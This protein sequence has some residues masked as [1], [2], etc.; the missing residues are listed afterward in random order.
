MKLTRRHAQL[1]AV[2]A[3][4]LGAAVAFALPA[5]AAVISKSPPA[6]VLKLGTT[7]TL[8]ANGAVVFAP[9]K[10]TCPV[11]SK[12]YENVTVTENVAGGFIAS[13]SGGS[14]D[15]IACTGLQQTISQAVTP[16]QRAFTKGVAFGQAYLNVC[17]PQTCQ[18]LT[19]QR[20]IQIVKP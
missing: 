13:G 4:G 18:T 6:P 7:A 15:S 14:N 10:I 2:S 11:G 3:I 16:T 19:D 1:L 12:A 9:V 17:G 5:G 8:E 20:V